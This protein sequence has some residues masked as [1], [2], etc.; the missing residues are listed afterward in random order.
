MKKLVFVILF[1]IAFCGVSFAR[2]SDVQVWREPGFNPLSLKK[3]FVY[4][5]DGSNLKAGLQKGSGGLVP[6][7]YKE[8]NNLDKWVLNGIT[9]AFK[10]NRSGRMIAKDYNALVE[11]M[12][13]IYSD[14]NFEGDIFYKRAA[15]MGYEGFVVTTIE[16]E[17]AT[18]HIPEEVRTYTEYREVE[19][20]DHRGRLKEV[21]RIPEEKYE[22]I[23]AHDVQYLRTYCAP[24]LYL[25]SDYTG[26]HKAGVEYTIYR[27]YQ[28]GPVMKVVENIIT[29]SM[30]KMFSK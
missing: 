23:P 13:F 5:V 14:N 20:Y 21:L 8:S 17:F 30:Q 11:D 19:V 7:K 28:G 22:V 16:Q 15:E 6:D 4:P 10:K 25:L 26:E 24:R 2:D 12:R 18:E 9:S 3:I 29:A 27:E 1:I